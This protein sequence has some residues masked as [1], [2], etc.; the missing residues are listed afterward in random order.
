MDEALRRLEAYREAGA[1]VLLPMP[2]TPEEA[3]IC[4]E[5][6]GPP[7]LMLLPPGGVAGTGMTA[8]ELHAHG[9]RILV[10]TQTPLLAAHEIWRRLYAE[11]ADGFAARS[12][13]PADWQKLQDA[14]HETIGLERLLDVER[15]TVETGRE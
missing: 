8:A 5:R 14:V 10:D 4:G 7:M 12:R 13:S 11:M 1:D 15:Q 2:R 9:F 6:L 3:R